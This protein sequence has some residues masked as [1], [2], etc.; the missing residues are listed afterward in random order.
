[1]ADVRCPMCGKFNPDILDYCQFCQARLKPISDKPAEDSGERGEA[2][3]P[4]IAG[5][6][7]PDWLQSL[8]GKTTESL[9]EEPGETPPWLKRIRERSREESPTQSPSDINL[10][11]WE[12][13]E[14]PEQP[15]SE[16]AGTAEESD[17]LDELRNEPDL[18]PASFTFA[19]NEGQPDAEKG[20]A[21][22]EEPEWLKKLRLHKQTPEP[23]PSEAT[24][25]DELE[26]PLAPA[27]ISPAPEVEAPPLEPAAPEEAYP[28]VEKPAETG[29]LLS[30]TEESPG[31]SPEEPILPES[32][33]A[34]EASPVAEE[35][36]ISLES[37]LTPSEAEA[38]NP[39]PSEQQPGL[40]VEKPLP[41]FPGQVAGGEGGLFEAPSRAGESPLPVP[42]WLKDFQ[43]QA[44]ATEGPPA[45]IF[46]SAPSTPV[47][48][49]PA[50]PFVSTE[51]PDWLG[52]LSPA[53]GPAEPPPG[54]GTPADQATE[55]L[56]QTEM[57]S[58]IHAMR[59]IESIAPSAPSKPVKED[60][61]EDR[62]PLAGLKGI[63]PSELGAIEFH[64]PSVLSQ[65]VE[66]SD[67]QRSHQ[68]LLESLMV[69]EPEAQKP[70]AVAVSQQ[71]WI[72]RA[73]IAVV[74]LAAILYPIVSGSR[75]APL[76]DVYPVEVQT[77]QQTISALAPGSP[78]LLAVDYEP[79]LA[80]EMQAISAD[81]VSQLM[82]RGARL[83]LISTSPAGQALAA[84]LVNT[85]LEKPS[86]YN[87]LYA[88]N[89]LVANLG[90][91]PGGTIGLLSF[92]TSPAATVPYTIDG[93]YAWD[94]SVLQNV[95]KISDFKL[96]V[97]FTEN[98]DTG[99]AWV[100]QVG[101]ALGS[102]PFLLVSSAQAA[103]MLR[104]YLESGQFEGMVAGLAGGAVLEELSAQ[105]GQASQYWDAYQAGLWAAI[106]MI[107]IGALV[108]GIIVLINNL[109]AK[110]GEA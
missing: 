34:G 107:V 61:V 5:A 90:Y 55:D 67:K 6:E 52:K 42:D 89:Q 32:G 76:P 66:I 57:P 59:P 44:P 91:L 16:P 31:L 10:P 21:E 38:I 71:G 92:A 20:S 53:V 80:G 86:P 22:N 26:E 78:V 50:S 72:W 17:W 84:Q 24:P 4:E 94:S 12:L 27:E 69:V 98:A 19:M 109:K 101:P 56:A 2:A 65:T 73:V 64:K 99:R 29:V 46:M 28:Q 54:A 60:R 68:A 33:P 93:K 62:G 110:K 70:G 25:W 47:D 83:V 49:A 11:G 85:V 74:L 18:L 40:P 96:A 58:W 45:P 36:E 35:I 9:P 37:L 87:Q 81:V 88:D 77:I 8:R 79:S 1:M 43:A 23:E 14:N 51:L 15:G 105:P 7:L 108:Q 102:T 3:P 106:A 75:F 13:E 41:E 82:S 104:P 39:P 63:L 95:H 30:P 48:E 103:P 97:L 100:E